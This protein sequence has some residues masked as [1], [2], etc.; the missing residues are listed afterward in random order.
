MRSSILIIVFL[1][2]EIVPNSFA[3]SS[4]INAI[5][6]DGSGDYA[7][8][9]NDPFFPTTN[10]TLEVF[11]LVQKNFRKDNMHTQ[12]SGMLSNRGNCLDPLFVGDLKRR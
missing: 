11:I 8:T 10:G 12:R 3:Q 4:F 7:N 1:F 2:F 6:F 5:D 9:L